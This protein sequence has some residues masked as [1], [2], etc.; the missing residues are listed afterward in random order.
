MYGRNWYFILLLMERIININY[1]NILSFGLPHHVSAFRTKKLPLS[2][3][4][5]IYRNTR[6]HNPENLNMIHTSP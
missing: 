6:Y 1:Y 5:T 3:G 4:C 2:S